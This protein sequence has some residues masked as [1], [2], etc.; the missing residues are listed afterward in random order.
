MKPDYEQTCFLVDDIKKLPMKFGIVTACNPDG[1][2]VSDELNTAAT[3]RLR[4]DLTG[5][6]F[7][8]FSVT[9]CSRDL[10][11]Q[12]PGFGI[13][14]SDREAIVE[15][16]RAWKQDAVFWVEGGIVY[17]ISCRDPE[18]INVGQW[19]ELARHPE[20]AAQPVWD[21]HRQE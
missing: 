12:E 2:T 15:L 14:T 21:R 19:Q 8:I 1:V 3:E 5:A 11:H 17:L 18:V 9:G 7:H 10:R 4:S 16:G 20:T 13:V 6:G